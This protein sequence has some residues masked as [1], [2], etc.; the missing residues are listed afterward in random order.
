MT[1]RSASWRE[2]LRGS[3]AQR[4]S[5]AEQRKLDEQARKIERMQNVIAEITAENIELKETLGT[6]E[7]GARGSRCAREDP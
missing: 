1:S 7:R 5:S 3:S 6:C 2:R 4:T